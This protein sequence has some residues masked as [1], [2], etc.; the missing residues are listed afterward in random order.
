MAIQVKGLD[1]VLPLT[2]QQRMNIKSMAGFEE[3]QRMVG[4][5]IDI[6]NLATLYCH[7]DEKVNKKT[8]E[9]EEAKDY[10]RYICIS[11]EGTMYVTSSETFKDDVMLYM[12]EIMDNSLKGVRVK[13]VSMKSDNNAGYFF[14]A[15]VVDIIE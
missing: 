13:I 4:Q 6:E 10:N 1:A 3:I 7:M 5:E 15:Q 12:E 14:K 9:V 8:G 11:P 2:V